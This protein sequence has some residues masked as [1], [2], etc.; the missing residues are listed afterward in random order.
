M[1]RK[2]FTLIELLVVIAVVVILAGLVV[3]AVRGLTKGNDT[4]QAANLVRSYIASA[5]SIAINQ[6]RM[7][8]V[9]FFE[10]SADYSRPADR[11]RTAMQIFVEDYNQQKRI[12]EYPD[13]IKELH[14]AF[15]KYSSDRQYLPGSVKLATLSDDI[16]RFD[17]AENTTAGANRTRCIIFDANGQLITRDK[18]VTQDPGAGGVNQGQYPEAYGDWKFLRP[19][20]QL[21]GGAAGV[22]ASS[23]AFLLYPKAEYDATTFAS[24][25]ERREWIK[26]HADAVIVNPITG[27]IVH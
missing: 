22:A 26:N 24:D 10:E 20:G 6:H 21:P 12:P 19:D 2:A 11:T 5:R 1:N 4:A 7:A 15:I 8:G 16:T 14:T 23:P 17:T 9:V 3:P 25:T 13:G 27:N 18:L